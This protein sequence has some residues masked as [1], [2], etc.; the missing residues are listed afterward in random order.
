[1][2]ITTLNRW[3]SMVALILLVAIMLMS[4]CSK[5]N[6]GTTQRTEST[7]DDRQT[8]TTP[9]QDISPAVT[10]EAVQIDTSKISFQYT[11][12][13]PDWTQIEGFNAKYDCTLVED[14]QGILHLIYNDYSLQVYHRFQNTGGVWSEPRQIVETSMNY[15]GYWAG[16]APDGSLCF[17][18]K[19]STSVPYGWTD[20]LHT[21]LFKD[22]QWEESIDTYD[23]KGAKGLET[24]K[25]SW[26]RV[27]FDIQGKPH[28]FYSADGHYTPPESGGEMPLI[29]GG[30]F[31]D[32]QQLTQF[33]ITRETSS[34][35]V[36]GVGDIGLFAY[37]Y[38]DS[39]NVYHLMGCDENSLIHPGWYPKEYSRYYH[40]Y[41]CDGGMTWEG[42]STTFDNDTY[43]SKISFAEDSNGNLNL[44]AYYPGSDESSLLVTTLKPDSYNASTSEGYFG[45][46]Q[47]EE[48]LRELPYEERLMYSSIPFRAMLFDSNGRPHYIAVGSWSDP[49]FDMTQIKGNAWAVRDID[50]PE[51]DAEI[52]I[53]LPRRNGNFLILAKAT[54]KMEP[55]LYYTEIRAE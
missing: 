9:T 51:D 8:T 2:N 44:M 17:A 30:L 14:A 29:V 21:K 10:T 18:W 28:F 47:M 52:I 19:E 46:K 38:I 39:G 45:E 27:A 15:L 20:V 31:L 32:G 1:M 36:Q 13:S 48:D 23:F 24:L 40:S 53:L 49:F 22:G 16:T 35:V 37:F 7:T 4:G 55:E 42:P 25:I 43:I 34:S 50:K 3:E 54:G 33:D 11:K 6:D 12:V 41:S 26:F 5:S